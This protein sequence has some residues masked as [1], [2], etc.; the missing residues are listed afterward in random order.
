MVK[1]LPE[2]MLPLFTVITGNAWTV[3]VATA[4]LDAGQPTELVPV[5][6]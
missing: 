6:E 4:V 3:T 5:T 1:F 2:Q